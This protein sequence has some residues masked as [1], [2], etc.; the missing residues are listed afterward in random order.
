MQTELPDGMIEVD[1]EAGKLLGFTS[2]LF[3][4]DSYLWKD[5]GKIVV[6]FIVSQHPRAG[7]FRKLVQSILERGFDV[8]VSNPLGRM[9][10]I[11]RKCG[12]V[13]SCEYDNAMGEFV[14]LWT[15]SSEG[16]VTQC[17]TQ[18]CSSGGSQNDRTN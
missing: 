1:S 13:Y 8:V 17:S 3:M 12:Y 11:L 7:N 2:D 18:T 10:S 14:E 16:T 15:L 9:E 6:S 5:G 4:D